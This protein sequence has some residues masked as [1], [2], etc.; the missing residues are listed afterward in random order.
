MTTVLLL[1]G[2]N[3]GGSGR[4]PMA[5]V[6]EAMTAAGAEAPETCIQS[7]NAVFGGDVAAGDIAREIAARAG[8]APVQMLMLGDAFRAALEANPF[9]EAEGDPRSL[10]LFF[11]SEDATATE[12]DLRA[13][14]SDG[15]LVVLARRVIY[16]HTPKYLRSSRLAPRLDRI[17]G[18]PAT[19]RNWRT[20]TRI[21]EMVEQRG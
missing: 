5:V 7:G 19:G 1:R 11:L 2:I 17:L 21:A 18:V 10:H 8:F 3:V 16:L 20:L 9:P 15:E 4:L 12:E 13:S 14:A 6:K